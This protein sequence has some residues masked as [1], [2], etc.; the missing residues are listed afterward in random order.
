MQGSAA[1][2]GY[3]ALREGLLFGTILGILEIVSGLLQN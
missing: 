1:R 3:P 2:P